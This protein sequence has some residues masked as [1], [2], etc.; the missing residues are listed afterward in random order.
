MKAAKHE[1][2][3]NYDAAH[4]GWCATTERTDEGAREREGAAIIPRAMSTNIGNC[5]IIR[6]RYIMAPTPPTGSLGSVVTAYQSSSPTELSR[7]NFPQLGRGP[8]GQ[9]A[10]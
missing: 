8:Q 2:N 5:P 6:S 7:E 3:H 9:L 1:P 10:M 4:F